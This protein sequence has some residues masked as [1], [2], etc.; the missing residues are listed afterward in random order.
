MGS[1]PASPAACVVFCNETDVQS[2]IGNA[3]YKFFSFVED[4][5]CG[6]VS[7]SLLIPKVEQYGTECLCYQEKDGRPLTG[8]IPRTY[9]QQCD[10]LERFIE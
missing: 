10:L 1:E 8:V 3:Q 6:R 4:R 2:T 7:R 5:L 9:K